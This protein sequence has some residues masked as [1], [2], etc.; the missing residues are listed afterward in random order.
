MA[1]IRFS[2]YVHKDRYYLVDIV[3]STIS[4]DKIGKYFDLPESAIIDLYTLY[5]GKRQDI[6]N[7]YS[8]IYLKIYNMYFENETDVKAAIDHLNSLVVADKLSGI[9]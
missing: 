9:A 2:F 7:R 3:Q 8:P 6:I 5:G 4:C 1:K